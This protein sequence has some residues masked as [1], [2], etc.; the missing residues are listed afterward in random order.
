MC[1]LVCWFICLFV[2]WLFSCC[3]FALLADFLVCL[4]ACLLAYM[5]ACLCN[6][7][8]ASL[9]ASFQSSFQISSSRLKRGDKNGNFDENLQILFRARAECRF[10]GSLFSFH[11]RFANN[12]CVRVWKGVRTCAEG[13]ACVCGRACV[14]VRA[15]KMK[16]KISLSICAQVK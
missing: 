14:R 8:L 16:L 2:F 13:R 1:L 7:L 12:T 15:V 3:L 4:T 6:V 11:L 5:H 9:F 10:F